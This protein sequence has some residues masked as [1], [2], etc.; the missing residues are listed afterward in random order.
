MSVHHSLNR[1][2][3]SQQEEEEEEKEKEKG[4]EKS[5]RRNKS[6]G[7]I[8]FDRFPSPFSYP[9]WRFLSLQNSESD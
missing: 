5:K 4:E 2:K 9:T 3:I 1:Q 6:K 8:C 7:L